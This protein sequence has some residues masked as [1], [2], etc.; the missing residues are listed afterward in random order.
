VA[1]EAQRAVDAR[2]PGRDER[3]RLEERLIGGVAPRDRV[4]V[5]G[6]QTAVGQASRIVVED[7]V[8]VPQRDERVAR[9]QLAQRRVGAVQRVLGAVVGE[10]LGRAAFV[11]AHRRPVRARVL[12]VGVDVVAE[13]DDEVE[14]VLARHHLVGVVEAVRVVGARVEREAHGLARVIRHRGLEA[15]D[16]TVLVARL[17]AV[18]VVLAG[19]QAAHARLD[20]VVAAGVRADRAACDDVLEVLVARH[21][22]PDA[23][24]ALDVVDDRRQRDPL[25]RRVAAQD[26]LR[27]LAAAQQLTP[28][29]PT[30]EPPVRARRTTA[31]APPARARNWRRDCMRPPSVGP[32]VTAGAYPGPTAG[33]CRACASGPARAWSAAWPAR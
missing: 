5:G 11:V 28:T 16:R 24:G 32:D 7:L 18:V 14:V 6:G 9:V 17:E 12:D 25:R 19:L 4:A 8:V 30:R 31:P 21:L 29:S 15:P 10:R 27:E 22:E 13:A 33:C 2:A 23:A 20:R 26:A 3:H 1:A